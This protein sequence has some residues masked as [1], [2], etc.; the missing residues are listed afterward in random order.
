MIPDDTWYS[1]QEEVII[2]RGQVCPGA[3]KPKELRIGENAY[4]VQPD[5][6]PRAGCR[7]KRLPANF[8]VGHEPIQRAAAAA[9]DVVALHTN[10]ASFAVDWNAY[11]LQWW[12]E[13]IRLRLFFS[14]GAGQPVGRW[15]PV[16]SGP[17]TG[18]FTDG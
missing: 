2:I 17:G 15:V 13:N 1:I 6:T 12:A 7:E 9:C 18:N 10:P 16:I 14:A 3:L 5:R 11:S 8:R 4:M